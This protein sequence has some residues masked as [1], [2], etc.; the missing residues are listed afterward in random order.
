MRRGEQV[1]LRQGY[2]FECLKAAEYRQAGSPAAD[3]MA[4]AQALMAGEPLDA[5]D[6]AAV[7]GERSR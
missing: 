2:Q 6:E 7:I 5:V 1:R 4:D 3:L